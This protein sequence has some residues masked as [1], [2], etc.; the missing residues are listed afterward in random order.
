MSRFRGVMCI[1]AANLRD[2]RTLLSCG[3]HDDGR[4]RVWD[5]RERYTVA[6]IVNQH[7]SHR[8]TIYNV[9]LISF[10]DPEFTMRDSSVP[11]EQEFAKSK[12]C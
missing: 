3:Y 4:L 10:A 12:P 7:L 6:E 2:N 11:L 8:D 5:Y 9:N 1:R